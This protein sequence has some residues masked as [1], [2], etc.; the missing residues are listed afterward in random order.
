MGLAGCPGGASS[1]GEVQLRRLHD[2][3]A[4]WCEG[5]RRS[6]CPGVGGGWF[7]AGGRR[8]T[9]AKEAL[10]GPS[11]SVSKGCASEGEPHRS[12][13]ARGHGN[14]P[15]PS[16]R[17]SL[18]A[19]TSRGALPGLHGVAH[20]PAAMLATA[21]RPPGPLATICETLTLSR[22]EQQQHPPAATQPYRHVFPGC[23]PAQPSAHRQA[24]GREARVRARSTASALFPASVSR[25]GDRSKRFL[26]LVLQKRC[27]RRVAHMF[28]VL[29]ARKR[30]VPAARVET[31][32][33][34]RS[35]PNLAVRLVRAR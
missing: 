3:G 13:C 29:P 27:Y 20:A 19:A 14:H 10:T 33:H 31:T 26:L 4:C 21:P 15:V 24:A 12:R 18:S 25:H 17:T 9:L 8:A 16:L 34:G 30:L 35:V 11:A 28:I 5:Q 23:G 22:P 1:A 32:A 2:S 6:G 7:S